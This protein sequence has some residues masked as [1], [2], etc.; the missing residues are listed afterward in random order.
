[1]KC[2]VWFSVEK[3]GFCENQNLA[4]HS[5]DPLWMANLIVIHFEI[6][7]KSVSLSC[8]S[9]PAIWP[10]KVLGNLWEKER[11]KAHLEFYDAHTSQGLACRSWCTAVLDAAVPSSQ[12]S[13]LPHRP[14][15]LHNSARSS[16][17]NFPHPY[18]SLLPRPSPVW[19]SSFS[20]FL[21]LCLRPSRWGTICM[22]SYFVHLM[23]TLGRLAPE[24]LVPWGDDRQLPL[25][26]ALSF[27][28][29]L[30]LCLF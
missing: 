4:G 20:P 19:F 27:F 13:C 2:E 22:I 29:F 8:Q 26:P 30:R 18:L 15:Q 10:L 24:L 16:E 3:E 6:L 9:I 17:T 25:R 1:M 21:C 23:K 14:A 28:L 5:K 11:W 7:G 12:I